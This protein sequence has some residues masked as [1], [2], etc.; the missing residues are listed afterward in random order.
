MTMG[1]YF[2]SKKGIL[3]GVLSIV[4]FSF[5]FG[6]FDLIIKL[7]HYGAFFNDENPLIPTT[8]LPIT[9]FVSFSVVILIGILIVAI[10]TIKKKDGNT[11]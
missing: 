5:A 10:S 11:A 3:W 9:L 6:G 4:L 7:T 2:E 1:K 8:I